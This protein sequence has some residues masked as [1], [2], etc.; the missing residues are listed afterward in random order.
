MKFL[1][2]G[3]VLLIIVL[4]SFSY[5]IAQAPPVPENLY[6][7]SNI[8]GGAMLKWD[9]SDGATGYIVYK[10]LD[11]SPFKS[12]A[13]VYKTFYVDWW[14]YPGIIYQ[15]YVTSFKFVDTLFFESSPS[16]SVNFAFGNHHLP[17][18]GEGVIGGRIIDASSGEP[19]KGAVV[20]FYSRTRL[21]TEK[22]HTDST[23]IYWAALDTG[24]YL[25]RADHFGFQGE[26]FDNVLHVDSATVVD[27]HEDSII[28]ANF[29]LT[30]LPVPVQ[31]NVRGTVTDHHTGI[32]LENAFVAYLRPHKWFRQLQAITGFFGGFLNERLDIPSLGKYFGVFWYGLTDENGNYNAT[33]IRGMRYI[34]FAFKPGYLPEFYNDK[35][36]PFEADR[37]IFMSDSSGI[38]FALEGNP[39]ADYSLSGSVVDSSGAGIPSHVILYRQTPSGRLGVRHSMT[40][41]LGNF[42][43][44]YLVAGVFYVKAIPIDGYA[45]AWFSR[46]NCGVRYWRFADSIQVGGDVSGI[47]ICVAPSP[48]LGFGGIAGQIYR[49]SGNLLAVLPEQS[50]TVYAVS[51]VSGE[52]FGNDISEDNGSYEIDGL[53]PGSYSIFIDKEGFDASSTPIVTI[54]ESNGYAMDGADVEVI[55]EVLGV[56]DNNDQIP[57]EF[58]LYQN[59]PN[60]FNPTTEIQFDVPK[61]SQVTLKIYNVI[62]QR[63]AILTDGNF[64]AGHHS[65]QW[66]ASDFGSGIYFMK[67]VAVPASGPKFTMVRKMLLMK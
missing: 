15:Y 22:T 47:N 67:I 19:L 51:T 52:I 27:L 39:V 33:L 65:I 60:P 61:A 16:T 18:P 66:N 2:Q 7:E 34:A 4:F 10:S 38:N 57:M 20:R 30:K 46:F 59:Y 12:I 49:N 8:C 13:I 11:S 58:N 3:F 56:E 31:V 21:Y 9:E 37:L 36:T 53:P 23:G 1:L 48:R 26:W 43:F 17:L 54:D 5:L 25:I 42:Q 40:D 41:S 44:S 63:V 64:E 45:P 14:V 55:A 32:P 24:R 29:D 62:G 35:I 50:V 28:I 6:V